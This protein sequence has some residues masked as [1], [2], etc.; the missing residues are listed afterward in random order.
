[1]EFYEVIEKRHSIREFQDKPIQRDVLERIL[2]AGLKA[3]SSNH[4]RQWELLTITDKNTIKTVA[5]IV[6][7]Y[8]CRIT[9][10]KTPQQ[11]MFKIAY[12]LQRKMIEESACVILPYFKCK[13]DLK[14]ETNNYG[15]MDFAAAWALVE[16]LLLAA[17][18]EGL[19]S[20]VHF[21]VKKEPEQI[22]ELFQVSDG[23]MLSALVVLGYAKEGAL[24]PRQVPATIENKVK[25]NKW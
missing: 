22:K 21:P 3:P 19:G 10:P 8:Y 5:K 17:T 1:M 24:I 2:N 9:E 16:N 20:V 7:P 6:K 11:D 25:W 23:Y 18:A 15:L 13:Y 14:S 12:P 4:Q